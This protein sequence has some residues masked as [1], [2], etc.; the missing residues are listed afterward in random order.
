[1]I[2]ATSVYC[3]CGRQI[4][5]RNLYRR[6]WSLILEG[7]VRY[8]YGEEENDVRIEVMFGIKMVLNI[9]L[10]FKEAAPEKGCNEAKLAKDCIT[11]A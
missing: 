11:Y 1:M 9:S 8:H 2:V 7:H 3:R 6:W 10:H 4:Q 5:G